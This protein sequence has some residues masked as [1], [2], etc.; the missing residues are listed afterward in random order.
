LLVIVGEGF[1]VGAAVLVFVGIAVLV[2]VGAAVLVLVG[3]AVGLDESVLVGEALG[4]APDDN[5][6]FV[7]KFEF[8]HPIH[9][10]L[11]PIHQLTLLF[12]FNDAQKE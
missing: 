1:F 3:E 8:A 5:I 7:G 10:L 2:F 11:L 4:L 12:H 9:G 6:G